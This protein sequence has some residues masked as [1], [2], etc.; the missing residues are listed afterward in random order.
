ML[1]PEDFAP[2]L[3]SR[4]ESWK[5]I[6]SYLSRD[7]RTAQRWEKAEGLPVHRQVHDA[8][9][10]IYAYTAELDAWRTQRA[11][12]P[13]RAVPPV[14]NFQRP[15][16]RWAVALV[17]ALA[18]VTSGDHRFHTPRRSQERYWVML[19]GFEN[20][21]GEALFEGTLR[22][23]LERELS[24]SEFLSVAPRERVEDALRLMRRPADTI[25]TAAEA[26]EVC[27]RDGGISVLVTGRTEKLGS[28]YLVSAEVIDPAQNRTLASDTETAAGPDQIWPAV[29]RL[30]NWV[31]ETLGE[32]MERIERSNRQ[33]EKVTTPSLRALQLFTE[34][35]SAGRRQQWSASAQILREA[36]VEDPEF[37]AARIWL[38]HA[39]QLL[40]DPEWKLEAKRAFDLSDRVSERERYFLIGTYERM[41][42]H[43]DRAI[44]AFEALLHRYPDPS[45][46]QTLAGLYKLSNR[47]EESDR[48]VAE[49]A[50]A[51][52]NDPTANLMALTTYESVDL[53]KAR[54]YARRLAQLGSVEGASL[55]TEATPVLFQAFDLWM[56]DDA[57]GALAEL[58][59]IIPRVKASH[60]RSLCRA[61]MNFQWT[62]GRFHASEELIDSLPEPDKTVESAALSDLE[63][64]L[65]P[66]RSFARLRREAAVGTRLGFESPLKRADVAVTEGR[67]AAAAAL[68]QQFYD[69][70]RSRRLNSAIPV[71]DQLISALERS[72][73][74]QKALQVMEQTS[75]M[76][77]LS[78]SGAGAGPFWLLNQARLSAYYRRLGRE[79]E[80]RKIDNQLRKL[81]VVADADHP[82]LR[83]LN[84]Q[85]ARPF[86][87]F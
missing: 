32:T 80:A 81:L 84:R 21:T 6:A 15:F 65:E 8:S 68:L 9:A 43:P 58:E 86:W 18:L 72:G 52:P 35:A 54:P 63:S 12:G 10:S 55:I 45:V 56:R 87:A 57:R 38:A 41:M 34:A 79:T 53:V 25:L 46:Y 59:R 17:L 23:A 51:R 22:A 47:V 31:R 40:G 36:L 37:A 48:L 42:G 74:S 49:F 75:A 62:L 1:S 85:E 39:E 71:A 70:V 3:G 76:R 28:T 16:R 26:R 61:V 83:Q 7:I 29:R 60:D 33:L 73:D 13:S 5:E 67:F 66:D 14:T 50:E 11:R 27:L 30:S 19:E 77:G 20:R 78:S 24:N 2:E 82:I 4:L 64:D 44:P 69:Q